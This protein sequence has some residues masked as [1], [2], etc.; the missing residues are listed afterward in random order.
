M[1]DETPRRGRSIA[2]MRQLQERMFR[3]EQIAAGIKAY[4]PRPTDVIIAPFDPNNALQVWSVQPE[5][6]AAS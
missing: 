3:P 1:N 2:E 6:G 5:G 4:R